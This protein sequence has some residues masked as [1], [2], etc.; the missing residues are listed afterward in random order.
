MSANASWKAS[1]SGLLGSLKRRWMPSSS[2]WVVSCATMSWL[3]QVK[4]LS[5]ASR[6]LRPS[7]RRR[8]VAEQQRLLR[9]AV[10]GVR[11]AQ[12]VRID[13]QPRHVLL[14]R[15]CRR[16][17]VAMRRPEREPAERALEVA[18]RPHR[19]GVDHL[20]VELR[21]ALRRRQAVLRDDRRVVEVDRLV[22]AAARRIVVDHLDVLADGAGLRG[23]PSL[24]RRAPTGLASVTSL[25]PGRLQLDADARVEGED[26]QPPLI[27]R[28]VTPAPDERFSRSAF[29]FRASGRLFDLVADDPRFGV[30]EQRAAG[31]ALRRRAA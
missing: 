12:R 14:R 4:T 16:T 28:R 7:D 30:D 11:L 25:M 17:C 31:R 23:C 21:V 9:R 1:T 5:G 2:A 3:R 24:C 26:S 27:G 15:T 29:L 10:V 22:E 8:E 6:R 19:D 20:L 13:A 18:D